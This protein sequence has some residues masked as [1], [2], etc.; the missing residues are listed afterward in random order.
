MSWLKI[1]GQHSELPMPFFFYR[2][3]DCGVDVKGFLMS[4]VMFNAPCSRPKVP[5]FG[6][7]LDNG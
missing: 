5:G 6:G 4:S 7:S 2:F 3:S 1:A